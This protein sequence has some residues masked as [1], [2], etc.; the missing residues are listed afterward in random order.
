MTEA[1]A[2]GAV[3]HPYRRRVASYQMLRLRSFPLNHILHTT[4]HSPRIISF[5][6][7]PH[8]PPQPGVASHTSLPSSSSSLEAPPIPRSPGNRS[9]SPTSSPQDITS[10]AGSDLGVVYPCAHLPPLIGRTIHRPCPAPVLLGSPLATPLDVLF[11]RLQLPLRGH[12]PQE[13][14]HWPAP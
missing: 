3:A 6:L 11:I 5:F 14:P 10:H 9:T 12:S 1:S 7:S 4:R 13:S 8:Q 2:G